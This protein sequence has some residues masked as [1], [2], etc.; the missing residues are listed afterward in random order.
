[1]NSFGL[2]IAIRSA[3]EWAINDPLSFSRFFD[4][5]QADRAWLV[6]ASEEEID[7][8]CQLPT[9][10]IRVEFHST[11]AVQ[12]M[13]S[14]AVPSAS[15]GAITTIL[16]AIADDLSSDIRIGMINWGICDIEKATWM[17]ETTV[18]DRLYQAMTGN[19][20]FSMR[21]PFKKLNA[22]REDA[23]SQVA[24]LLRILAGSR[25]A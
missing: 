18:Q 23:T 25:R 15:L 5:S 19:V 3:R 11:K 24:S 4:M 6:E 21:C 13:V 7:R 16:T 14:K 1:M 12:E 2:A 10:P 9:S 8:L 20:T 17:S 22:D